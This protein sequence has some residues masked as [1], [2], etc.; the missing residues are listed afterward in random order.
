MACVCQSS[1]LIRVRASGSKVTPE[2][3][4]RIALSFPGATES[5][6]MNHPDF[7]V[8]GKIFATLWKG[9]GVLLLRPD[10]QALL[11]KS[12]P[13]VFTPV[14]GG[15]GRKGS[16]TVHLDVADEGSVRRALSVAWLNKLRR[17]VE[18]SEDLQAVVTRLS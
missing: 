4:R 18:T 12:D 13:R 2:D 11:V 14:N 17:R 8:R 9:D 3:Y 16:T 10:Q 15:W 5:S 6:H 7:R 1:A